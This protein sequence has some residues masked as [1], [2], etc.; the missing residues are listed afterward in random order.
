MSIDVPNT[1]SVL[2]IAIFVLWAISGVAS[3]QTVQTQHDWRGRAAVWVVM[4]GWFLLFNSR[5]NLGP[6]SV[7]FVPESPAVAYAGLAIAVIGLAFAVWARVY[8]GRD[9]SA[10]VTLQEGH[11][12]VRTGPYAVVRH[13][14]YSGFM[15][16]SLGTAIALGPV[17]GLLGTALVVVAWGYKS[18]LEEVFLIEHFGAEY[19]HYRRDVKALIPLVW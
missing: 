11:K 5:A 17:A 3:K 9:W 19:E 8:I 14:I 16:A 15:L 2:W 13:P 18:R 10:A 1:L 7:R 4:L 12:I 6:L